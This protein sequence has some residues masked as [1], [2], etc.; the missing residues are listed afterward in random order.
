MR[1]SHIFIIIL[2]L[3][4][5]L[6]IVFIPMWQFP[7]EQAHFAQVQNTAENTPINPPNGFT[8]SKEIDISEFYLGTKRD[9]FGNNK[10]TYHPDFN[11]DYSSSLIGPYEEIFK[12]FPSKFRKEK[13]SNEATA[14]PP[15][16]YKIASL[17][18]R[19]V[20]SQDLI[21]RVF[22]SRLINLC[23]FLLFVYFVYLIGKLLLP[24]STIFAWVLTILVGFHPMLSFVYGGI[25]S[26]NLY[27]LLFTVGIYLGLLILKNPVR[28]S[29]IIISLI[30]I[31]LVGYTKPQGKL[32]YLVFMF[33]VLYRLW[34]IRKI[35]VLGSIF[36]LLIISLTPTVRHYIL[37][38]RLIEDL[39]VL[40][41]FNGNSIFS[42]ASFQFSRLK[43]IYRETMPWYWGVF[44]WLSH[45]Y[46]RVI[47]RALNWSV[48]FSGIGY[49]FLLRKYL[50]NRRLNIS[51]L[52]FSYLIYITFVYALS[53]T[54]YDYL[55]TTWHGFSLGLQG[56]YFFPTIVAHLAILLLGWYYLLPKAHK[57]FGLK[58]IGFAMIGLHFYAQIFVVTSY[59][60]TGSLRTFF[61][62]ASQY[63][64][65]F[66]KS[67][68]LEMLV[69]IYLLTFLYF[70]IKY[71]KAATK[72]K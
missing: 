7:D 59:F 43:K 19:T 37:N 32:I 47:H 50:K 66:F 61:T 16:Y 20:Y 31:I 6:W 36:F 1:F 22:V 55:F 33:P 13:V 54:T 30:L 69:F 49:I 35:F 70:V 64:P 10:F 45:T 65:W 4:Q 28:L 25:N 53:I 56:R 72:L 8:T 39:P 9:S 24:E 40:S 57:T 26:D 68:L 44:R 52:A 3:K 14:Y 60:D 21:T 23:L 34:H 38:T 41:E 12:R 11:L 48:I 46:P 15:L 42:Y 5:L 51:L 67:P 29:V 27:N 58:I 63:K 62:Q 2:L 17:A 18:Y 71:F